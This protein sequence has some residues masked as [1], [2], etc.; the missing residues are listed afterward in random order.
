MIKHLAFAATACICFVGCSGGTSSSSTSSTSYDLTAERGPIL[1][2]I[3]KDSKNK[4]AISLGNGQY[5]FLSTPVF[6]ITTYGGY[7]D[8]NRNGIVDS[9]DMALPFSLKS[10]TPATALS[11]VGTLASNTEIK[12]YLQTTFGLSDTQIANDTPKENIAIGVISNYVHRYLIQNSILIENLTIADLQTLTSSIQNEISSMNASYNESYLIAQEQQIAT[13]FGLALSDSAITEAQV[14]VQTLN[15][16]VITQDPTSLTQT[17]PVGILSDIQKQDLVYMF[18]EEKLARDV[19]LHLYDT[20]GL[21]IF[22]NIAQSEGQHMDSIKALLQKYVLHIPA[23][24]RGVFENTT[25]A[26]LYGQLTTSGDSSIISGLQI[27]IDIENLD[28]ED[29]V[30]RNVGV[31]ADVQLVYDSL[32]NGSYNHLSA[33]TKMQSKY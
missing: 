20:W 33:F 22:Y 7:I 31:P 6:P 15:D 12:A 2:A 17:L 27:G 23:D 10:N 21:K 11:I 9:G 30:A 5:R 4:S 16:T 13:D 19:Y 26:I 3:I 14:I 18:E 1:G 25:L 32:K 28:I 8:V 24:T 29:L